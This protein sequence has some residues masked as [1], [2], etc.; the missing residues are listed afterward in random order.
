[1]LF[2]QACLTPGFKSD[3]ITDPASIN[4]IRISESSV[5]IIF[6]E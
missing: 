1:M 5:E 6:A 4:T 2:Y 3:A